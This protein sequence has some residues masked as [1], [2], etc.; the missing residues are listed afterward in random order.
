VEECGN[1]WNILEMC[2]TLWKSMEG[3]GRK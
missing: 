1:L 3:Y 2:G